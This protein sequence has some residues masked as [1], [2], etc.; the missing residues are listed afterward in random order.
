MTHADNGYWVAIYGHEVDGP[1]AMWLNCSVNSHKNNASA[2]QTFLQHSLCHALTTGT[3]LLNWFWYT[4]ADAKRT[5]S[6]LDAD[7]AEQGRCER[8]GL[9]ALRVGLAD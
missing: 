6:E 9:S 1:K 2:W 8:V 7:E 5:R 3:V 4:Y